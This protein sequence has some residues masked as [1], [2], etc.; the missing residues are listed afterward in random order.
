MSNPN[1]ESLEE[2]YYEV[3]YSIVDVAF[4]RDF[5]T[6]SKEARALSGT[7]KQARYIAEAL[8]S[9]YASQGRESALYVA[10]NSDGQMV[11]FALEENMNLLVDFE[12]GFLPLQNSYE[13]AEPYDWSQDDDYPDGIINILEDCPKIYTEK[14]IGSYGFDLSDK[15]RGTAILEFTIKL[16]QQAQLLAPEVFNIDGWDA[17]PISTYISDAARAIISS[18]F[19][20]EPIVLQQHGINDYQCIAILLEEKNPALGVQY[21]EQFAFD[22]NGIPNIEAATKIINR[23]SEYTR[24]RRHELAFQIGQNLINHSFPLSKL[25]DTLKSHHSKIDSSNQLYSKLNNAIE[26]FEQSEIFETY[27]A[28]KILRVLETYIEDIAPNS[29]LEMSLGPELL[30]QANLGMTL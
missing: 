14:K 12:R 24:L 3:C 28:Q 30:D 13:F 17:E 29:D 26:D 27:L 4:M 22:K 25:Y 16:F 2:R 6:H 10:P 18:G 15:E 21:L 7:P 8:E 23:L 19:T 9:Y 5:I 1:A 20:I 11:T